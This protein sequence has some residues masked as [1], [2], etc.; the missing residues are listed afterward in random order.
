MREQD[1]I[2][3]ERIK[4]AQRCTAESE[5]SQW[6]KMYSRERL[7]K[8]PPVLHNFLQFASSSV[9]REEKL[10]LNST[11][12]PHCTTA[13]SLTRF[14]FLHTVAASLPRILNILAGFS[15]RRW[16]I[17]FK[18]VSGQRRLHDWKIDATLR[19][20]MWKTLFSCSRIGRVENRKS[21]E[22]GRVN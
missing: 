7:Q 6:E 20:S 17:R 11:T 22:S 4:I 15:F 3:R 10:L 8:L 12:Y 21:A 18:L 19:K 9:N 2:E 14:T 16:K 13:G 1:S 5:N